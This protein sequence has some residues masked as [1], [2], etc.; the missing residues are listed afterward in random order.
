[1][2][3]DGVAHDASGFVA[4]VDGTLLGDRVLLDQLERSLP[5]LPVIAGGPRIGSAIARPGKIVGIGL[6]YADHAA[7]A[8]VPVPQEP[9]VFL[10]APSSMIGPYDDITIPR[11]SIATDWE[12]EL[13]VVLGGTV[14]AGSTEKQVRAAI[15]GYVATNDVTERHFSAR[16]P[17]WAK[18]KCCDTFCPVGPWLVTADEIADPQAL[19]LSLWVNGERRQHSSTA[20]MAVGV[21]DLLLFLADL[22]TLEPGDLILT[23]TPS[24]VAVGRPEPKPFL[25]PGDL[26]ELEIEGL[27]RQRTQVRAF[28]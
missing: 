11:G 16:G 1:M 15:G 26:V 21:I 12:V 4:D 2:D 3:D 19:T 20:Q 23:G 7:E 25:R 18:G 28:A 9:V 17:T 10:K 5:K 27:G 22:M 24:G 14:S 8:G 13:G 6:N